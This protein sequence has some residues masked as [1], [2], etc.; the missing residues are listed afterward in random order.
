MSKPV[1]RYA[2]TFGLAGCYMPDSHGGQ[3]EVTTRKELASVIRDQ[4]SLYDL[5]A[6]LIR[7]VKLRRLWGFIKRH[8]SSTAH[9]NLYHGS[10]VLSFQ[11]L[12]E[13]E[14]AQMEQ[15]DR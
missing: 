6:R 1:A 4:L 15:E 12:T 10:N 7:E 13:D 14:F 5:P 9:F 8:G 2:V 11:G 3:Y